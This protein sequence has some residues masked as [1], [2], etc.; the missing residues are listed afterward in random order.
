MKLLPS[1]AL[2]A[3]ILAFALSASAAMPTYA[4]FEPQAPAGPEDP[5]AALRARFWPTKNRPKP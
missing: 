5:G 4:G 1:I 3:L 2:V